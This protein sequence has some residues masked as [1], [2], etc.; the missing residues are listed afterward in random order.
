MMACYNKNTGESRNNV[1]KCQF[2][3]R[4][5]FPMCIITLVIVMRHLLIK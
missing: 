1:M 5:Q 3:S 4:H 2:T